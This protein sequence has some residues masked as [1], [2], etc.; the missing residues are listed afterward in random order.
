MVDYFANK[1][2]DDYPDYNKDMYMY[3]GMTV[4]RNTDKL[5]L[6]PR[7]LCL[8]KRLK[9][10]QDICI[11]NLSELATFLSKGPFTKS[12]LHALSHGLYC[13]PQ[14]LTVVFNAVDKKL[15]REVNIHSPGA[16][17]QSKVDPKHFPA[18]S[19]VTDLYFRKQRF[20]VDRFCLLKQAL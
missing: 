12:H 7:A 1:D 18:I 9:G 2:P 15:C 14:T 13:P 11:R 20:T 10:V 6:Q 16:T 8:R 4:D 5:S 3:L 19:K 17:W